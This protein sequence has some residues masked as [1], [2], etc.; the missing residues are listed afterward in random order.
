[1]IVVQE[2]QH[3]LAAVV[4]AYAVNKVAATSAVPRRAASCGVG[5]DREG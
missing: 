4:D 5:V 2:V 1:M 3:A